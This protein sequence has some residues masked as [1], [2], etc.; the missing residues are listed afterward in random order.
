MKKQP[1]YTYERY[2]SLWAVVRWKDAP[3][4]GGQVGER[5]KTYI[6]KDDA[7]KEV[8]RLNGWQ[9]FRLDFS[10]NWNG[11]LHG[12]AFTT[13]RLWNE[14]KYRLEKEYDVYVGSFRRGRA[15]LI[16]IK[17]IK[18]HQINEH[19]ARLDTG[20]S[21]TECREMFRTMYKNKN[22]DWEK[23]DLAYCLF[24]F[25]YNDGKDFNGGGDE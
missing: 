18:L 4:G 25:P 13:I 6:L 10:H 19:I 15:K 8:Y 23:Q 5:I 3:S 14:K 7:R 2:S 1:E 9:D 22:I 24:V 12:K 16:S 21:A 11:K 20:F 17:R